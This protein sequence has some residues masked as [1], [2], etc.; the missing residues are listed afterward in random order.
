MA[1]SNKT[2]KA[3]VSSLKVLM[4]TKSFEK[5]TITEL[6][7]KC[8]M[9]R[10]SFYYHFHDKYELMNYVFHS[11]FVSCGGMSKSSGKVILKDL[12]D[13]LYENKNFY[14]QAFYVEGKNN[15]FDYF[16]TIIYSFIYSGLKIQFDKEKLDDFTLSFFTDGFIAAIKRWITN[17]DPDTPDI[18]VDKI[19]SL[20]K[21]F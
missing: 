8:S 1:N 4:E 17:R 20:V 18:F 15:F 5:I 6:C 21:N 9:N 7:E 12:C 3:L 11:E 16:Y 19:F 2:K 13:Y 10:K 14:K